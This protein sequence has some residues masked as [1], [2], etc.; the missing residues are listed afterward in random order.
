MLFIALGALKN[1]ATAFAAKAAF[2]TYF[3]SMGFVF[4]HDA[5]LLEF[6]VVGIQPIMCKLI[7]PSGKTR[8]MGDFSYEGILPGRGRGGK[9]GA[10][11][12]ASGQ[13]FTISQV[14]K[15]R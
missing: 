13:T 3:R 5:I 15:G 12:L 11:G 6:S 10:Y 9:G 2:A 1:V 4:R 14:R 8:G 7:N